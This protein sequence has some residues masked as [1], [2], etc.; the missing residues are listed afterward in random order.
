MPYVVGIDPGYVNLGISALELTTNKSFMTITDLTR[1]GGKRHA[2]TDQNMWDTVSSLVDIFQDIFESTTHVGIESQPNLASANAKVSKVS[3]HLECI[4][5]FR[6]PHI[7]IHLIAPQK[8][9]AFWETG[10]STYAERKLNSMETTMLGPTSQYHATRIFTKED[11]FHVDAIEALQLCIYVAV[12]RKELDQ[13]KTKV[14][15]S[16]DIKTMECE[17]NVDPRKRLVG[18]S[19]R[20]F[21]KKSKYFTNG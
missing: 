12:H 20:H 9:R 10:G 17:V 15:T 7:R 11:G 4:L 16:F 14:L 6:F 19:S 3:G 18:T 2:L 1:W 21:L 8:V 13:K 5:R